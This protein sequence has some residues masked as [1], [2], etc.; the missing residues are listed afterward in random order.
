V[1]DDVIATAG[2]AHFKDIGRAHLS[3]GRSCR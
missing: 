2:R 3:T 1:S